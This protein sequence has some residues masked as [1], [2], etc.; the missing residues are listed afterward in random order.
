MV[1]VGFDGRVHKWFRG[2]LARE[3][4]ENERRVLE[5]LEKRG[6]PFVPRVLDSNGDE[7]YLVTSNC[8]SRAGGLSSKK[9]EELFGSLEKFGVRHNDQAD[10]NITYD[11]RKGCFCVIDF[12]FATILKTGEGL[13]VADAEREHKRW[14]ELDGE[15]G[16]SFRKTR[17]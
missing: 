3:R 17:N 13:E 11:P 7:L 12:E 6:C 14:K 1:R 15:S 8:G 2:P 5:F 4:F 10:R 16:D 9:V